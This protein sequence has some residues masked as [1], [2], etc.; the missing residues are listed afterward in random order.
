MNNNFKLIYS[1]ENISE[2]EQK[3]I[4]NLAATDFSSANECNNETKIPVVESILKV[5]TDNDNVYLIFTCTKDGESG[6]CTAVIPA[7]KINFDY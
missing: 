5:Y 7:N 6:I 1:K 2:F 3:L 4:D